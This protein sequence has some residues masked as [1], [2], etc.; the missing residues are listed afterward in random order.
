MITQNLHINLSI[1]YDTLGWILAIVLSE[2][3]QK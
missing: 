2:K 3:E 1:S